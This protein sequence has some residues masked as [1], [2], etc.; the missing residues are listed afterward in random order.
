M[1]FLAAVTIHTG[2]YSSVVHARS[3]LASNRHGGWET[4]L[5]VPD[6]A[7][8]MDVKRSVPP[9]ASIEA[10]KPCRVR[11]QKSP[12]TTRERFEKYPDYYQYAMLAG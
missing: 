1:H 9:S 2:T 6:I 8:R 4:Y 3:Q 12:K 5:V 11:A 7:P 10:V